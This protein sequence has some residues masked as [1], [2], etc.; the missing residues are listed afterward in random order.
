MLPKNGLKPGYIGGP[1]KK[2]QL[3]KERKKSGNPGAASGYL[4]KSFLPERVT[5][6]Q[7]LNKLL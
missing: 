3:R 2:T 4:K 6:F 5:V 7:Q 1:A